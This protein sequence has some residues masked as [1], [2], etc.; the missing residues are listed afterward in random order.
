MKRARLL[1]LAVV[2]V[3]LLVG[4]MARPEPSASAQGTGPIPSAQQATTA[5]PVV[6]ARNCTQAGGFSTYNDGTDAQFF[7]LPAPF[8][9]AD[10][11]DDVGNWPVTFGTLKE[12]SL[13]KQFGNYHA[14]IVC[15]EYT[16]DGTPQ[17][18]L[19]LGWV[20]MK[21]LPP[22]F[23]VASPDGSPVTA[24][25][26]T[27]LWSVSDPTLR[28]EYQAA[29]VPATKGQ[30]IVVG[31][32][33]TTGAIHTVLDDSMHGRYESWVRYKDV[34]A[35]KDGITRLWFVPMDP[36]PDGKYHPIPIDLED[37]GG[38]HLEAAAP[39]YFQH[40]NTTMHE[41]LPGAYDA[42]LSLGYQIPARTIQVLPMPAGV[43]LDDYYHH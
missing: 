28:A 26:I 13:G 21:V 24:E 10:V 8:Q 20:G 1:A 12:P 3:A 7:P 19:R 35:E 9:R 18:D 33:P 14:S 32:D 40:T 16:L 43:G 6:H 34:G 2:S 29:G 15:S 27:I 4:C 42:A 30:Q 37:T 22:P 36:G 41:P 5:A 11:R 23:D 31:A 25:Y 17:K 38:H 39:G